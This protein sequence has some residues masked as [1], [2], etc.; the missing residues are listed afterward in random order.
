MPLEVTR[1]VAVEVD[2]VDLSREA[3]AVVI[4]TVA[5]VLIWFGTQHLED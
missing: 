5:A 2:L 1:D 4:V 3:W